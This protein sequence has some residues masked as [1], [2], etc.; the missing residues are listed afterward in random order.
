MRAYAGSTPVSL[1]RG[2]VLSRHAEETL[3]AELERITRARDVAIEQVD[4][5]IAT[6][7]ER[8]GQAQAN[9]FVAQK[10]ML[11]DPSAAG[12]DGPAICGKDL[13]QCRNRGLADARR[14]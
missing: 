13:G 1:G 6:V 12:R 14:I 3:G 11:E 5:L 4:T 8:V 9:I 2:P 10:L 7:T